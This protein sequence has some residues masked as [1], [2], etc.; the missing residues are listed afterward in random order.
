MCGENLVAT[1]GKCHWHILIVELGKDYMVCA[2]V[3]AKPFS[4]QLSATLW[5]IAVWAP[6]FMDLQAILEYLNIVKTSLSGYTLQGILP[7]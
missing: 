7:T 2:Y 4:V 6:L 3:C 1:V 5:I